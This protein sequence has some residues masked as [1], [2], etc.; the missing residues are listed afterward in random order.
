MGELLGSPGPRLDNLTQHETLFEVSVLHGQY[1]M[2]I[3]GGS[4][5][6]DLGLYFVHIVIYQHLKSVVASIDH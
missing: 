2:R 5:R 6:F 4:I 3:F 1:S